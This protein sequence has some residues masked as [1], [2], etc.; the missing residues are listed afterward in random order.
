M[1]GADFPP[2]GCRC[3]LPGL[4]AFLSHNPLAIFALLLSLSVLVPP[5]VRRVGLP[6]LVGLLAAGVLIGPHALGWLTSTSETVRLLA[7]VGVVY[8]LFIAG[9]AVN[10]VL[11]EGRVKQQVIFVGAALF[12][13]IF[14]I[15]LGLLLNLPAF[16]GTLAGSLFAV[17]MIGG[18]IGTNGLAAWWAGRLYRSRCSRSGP[19]AGG[20]HPGGHVC[21]LPGGAAG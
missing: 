4:S 21:G 17:L 1:P 11:P 19:A 8:L 9:L 7:D 2:S 14:F 13:P 6:D 3:A 12:I 10:A 16:L 18:L 20:R 5:L 15:D